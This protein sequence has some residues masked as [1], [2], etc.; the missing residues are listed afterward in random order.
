MGVIPLYWALILVIVQVATAIILL[1]GLSL[2]QEDHGD[3]W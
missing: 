3:F 1:P 2:S